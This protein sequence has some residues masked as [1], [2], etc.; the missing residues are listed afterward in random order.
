MAGLK[1]LGSL[2]RLDALHAGGF[3]AA[4]LSE[5]ARVDLETARAY[6]NTEKGP[7]YAEVIVGAKAEGGTAGRP[8]NLYRLRRERRADLLRRLAEV[9]QELDMAISRPVPSIEEDL[10]PLDLLEE[11]VREP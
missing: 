1:L 9:R 7:G 5:L 6:L 10:T 3:T 11:T 8:A 2:L 4:Q